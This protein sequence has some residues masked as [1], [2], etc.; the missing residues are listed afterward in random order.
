MWSRVRATTGRRFRDYG[1]RGITACDR[2]KSFEAFLADMGPRPAG[3]SLDR[4][5]NDGN[6]E[7][8]NCRWATPAQQNANKRRRAA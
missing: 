4:I 1:A 7:A 2:W 8:N 5:N 3:T 6:Y